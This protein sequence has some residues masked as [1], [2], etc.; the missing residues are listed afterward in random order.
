MNPIPEPSA[1]EEQQMKEE[2]RLQCEKVLLFLD[3]KRNALSLPEK[4]ALYKDVAKTI[5]GAFRNLFKK[6]KHMPEFRFKESADIITLKW[7]Y[8]S[9]SEAFTEFQYAAIKWADA[10]W[11]IK[12]V[13]FLNLLAFAPKEIIREYA[14]HEALHIIYRMLEPS[15]IIAQ[16]NGILV[17][18][19]QEDRQQE[20]QWVRTMTKRLGFAPEHIFLWQLAIESGG[21]EWRPLYYKWKRDRIRIEDIWNEAD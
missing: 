21:E 16:P 18:D 14:T 19:Y 6:M 9:S 15:C 4:Q 10:D 13:R 2:E 11:K 17:G 3:A 20:E 5:E 1:Q 8:F 12:T 7:K